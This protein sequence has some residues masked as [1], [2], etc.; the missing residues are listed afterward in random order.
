MG[1]RDISQLPYD[2]TIKLCKKYSR[3]RK[4]YG[5]GQRDALSKVPKS[6]SGGV[7]KD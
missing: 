4:K 5:R 2:K 6:D 3:G 1:A 7:T